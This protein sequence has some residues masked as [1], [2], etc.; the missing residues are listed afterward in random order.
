MNIYDIAELAGVSIAT[1]SRVVNNSSNVSS[2]TRE[3]VLEIMNN[4]GYTP[5]AFAR[6][7]G[8]GSMKTIG[9][10]CP[11]V[12]DIYMAHAVGVIEEQLDQYEYQ[13]LLMCSGYKQE[14]KEECVRTLLR[15]KVD[16]LILIG[17]TY[18][19]TGEASRRTTY[20]KEAARRIPVFLVNGVLPYSNVYCTCC[21]DYQAIYD[22]TTNLIQ[23]QCK[24]I[25]FLYNSNSYS[26]IQKMHG[27]EQALRDHHLSVLGE[28][29]V[30]AKNE[31]YHI[32]DLLLLKKDITFDGVIATEDSLAIGV[33]KYAKLGQI[34]IPKALKIIGYNNSFLSKC[35][36][37]ELSSID[38]MVEDICIHTTENL[39][40][41]LEHNGEGTKE[42]LISGKLIRRCTTDF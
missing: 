1:V 30:Y 2:K 5:N 26:A 31:I 15:K 6:G 9:I 12:S 27:Y 17:S 13:T 25:L 32:R 7:L 10:V 21:N 24:N 34:N 4:E 23:N 14:R 28:L 33:L 20:I 11:D 19:D 3:R 22:A 41:I 39:L 18:A 37:P 29:K 8:L 42:V 35:C 40:E 36:E 16:A 38:S